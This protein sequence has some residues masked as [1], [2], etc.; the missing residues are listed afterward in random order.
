MGVFYIGFF[1]TQEYNHIGNTR[2]MFMKKILVLWLGI[3][4]P[5]GVLAGE[6][7]D[8][9]QPYISANFGVTASD[10]KIKEDD[11][12]DF[13]AVTNF[14]FGTR[15]DS[16]YRLSLSYQ[17][18]AEVS[19][20]FQILAGHTVAISNNAIRVNGYYDY[21]SL[22]HFFMYIGAGV[23]GDLYD[24]KITR[25]YDNTTD[26]GHGITFTGG[27]NAGLGFN[28][29]HFS[30]DLG[31][32]ADYIAYPRVYSYGPTLGLRYNF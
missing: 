12:F 4:M 6:N 10:V 25:N 14:E 20:L 23:G 13:G 15:Y 29:W 3:I 16:R 8:V 24:Y 18:R 28:I 22:K 7:K 11:F 2:R 27:L 9:W 5:F 32:A 21:V 30:L 31:F 1:A 19:E 26:K 17:S